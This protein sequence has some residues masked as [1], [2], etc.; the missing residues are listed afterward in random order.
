M[1][2]LFGK[3]ASVDFASSNLM[4]FGKSFSRL[5]GQPLDKSE[6]WYDKAAL[7]AY[8]LT[9]A[10][11]V[12]QKVFFVD[13]ENSTVTHYG[14]ETDGSLK[15]LG[16]APV[17]DDK[18]IE[19]T[20]DGTISIKGFNALTAAEDTFLPRVKWV[21]ASEDVE[22]HAEIEWVSVSAVVEGDGN[23]V[24]KVTSTDKSVTVA[25]SKDAENDVITYDLSVTHPDMP[26]YAVKADERAEGTTS[27]TYHLTKDGENVEVA[28][29][30]PD[31]Y[32]DTDLSEKIDAIEEDLGLPASD[33]QEATGLF[34]TVDTKA[35]KIYV[36]GLVG[37]PAE[38][39]KVAT[40]IYTNV[41]TKTETDTKIGEAIAAADHLKRVIIDPPEGEETI[42]D[43]IN[44]W[45]TTNGIDAAAADEYIYM[46]PSGL[47][48]DDNKY[49]E[50]I[51]I[52]DGENRYAEQVGNWE[53][54]LNDYVTN[55]SLETTLGD[56]VKTEDLPTDHVTTT[57]LTETLGDYVKTT[58]LP[59][60]HVT[61]GELT[62]A[63]KSYALTTDIPTDYV[64]DE[65]IK[66]YDTAEVSATKYADKTSTE[67]G[68]ANRYTKEEV[69]N[70]LNDKANASSVYTK[71]ETD[72]L[73]KDKVD[74]SVATAEEGVRF[75]NQIEITKLSKLNL[76]GNDI[77]ISGSVNASQVKELYPTV[78]NII[79]GS[80]SD[81]DPD[82]DGNQLGLGI[83]EG[84]QVNIINSVDENIFN[85]VTDADS[86]ID[87]QLQLVKV[88]VGKLEGLTNEFELDTENNSLGIAKVSVGK[89][90]GLGDEFKV[91]N[92]I[93]SLV[94]VDATKITNL[95]KNT[96]Y[97]AQVGDLTK[98]VRASGNE[99]STI[100]DEI[101]DINT[102]LTWQDMDV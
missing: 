56:Y 100:V 94:A 85:I 23:T 102:R 20:T 16:T 89:L 72:N 24:T 68:L 1:A 75:I 58:D 18:S 21:E 19:V 70:L 10:A 9:D 86:S 4:S 47:I 81:L 28:I 12:G 84:A 53:V 66:A 63:L 52:I 42:E 13:V 6:V 96:I 74:T 93:L 50:Y 32:D 11:Y 90:E 61:T 78:V 71:E 88:P 98:L 60:D 73:L 101:N 39:E 92:S 25:E 40:G 99:N 57:Q 26:E 22:A 82:T 37:A 43:V 31:A 95:D 33:G 35:D 29:I 69:D 41:Y 38:G 49:Y 64:S 45:L 80:A 5:N 36:D 55:T 7:E 46:V 27:T 8:A 30:V 76:E 44:E 34:A 87:R 51:I 83:E 17:G 91:E 77:T 14:I 2:K 54:D 79:K 48:A 67:E 3:D 97:Q 15:E 59:K 65:E 62:E